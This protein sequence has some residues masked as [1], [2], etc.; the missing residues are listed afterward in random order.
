[1]FLAP[2][3]LIAEIDDPLALMHERDVWWNSIAAGL[4]ATVAVPP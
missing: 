4:P 3:A 2:F 1:M